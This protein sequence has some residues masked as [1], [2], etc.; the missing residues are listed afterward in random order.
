MTEIISRNF[1][2]F[3]QNCIDRKTILF[4]NKYNKEIIVVTA[5]DS[6]SY[7]MFSHNEDFGRKSNPLYVRSA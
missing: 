2:N 4:Y 5:I 6:F 7:E 1:D 3:G